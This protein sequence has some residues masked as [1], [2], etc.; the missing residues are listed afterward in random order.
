MS[1][2]TLSQSAVLMVLV[3][4]FAATAASEEPIVGEIVDQACFLRNGSHGDE[5]R[6]CAARCL[7]GGNAAG[8][9]TDAGEL[10]TLAASSTGYEVFAARRV[11]VSGKTIDRTILPE[12]VEVWEHETW[13]EVP[14]DKYGAPA[15]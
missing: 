9:L 8:V 13:V 7:K 1:Y 11:R 12:S 4:C 3:A 14:L 15:K 6:E 10:Y 2:R 5:H